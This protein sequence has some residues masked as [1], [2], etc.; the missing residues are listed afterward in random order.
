MRFS[1]YSVRPITVVCA[2]MCLSSLSSFSGL[3]TSAH[4]ENPPTDSDS[5]SRRAQRITPVVRVFQEASPAVVNISTTTV[6]TVQNPAGFGSLFDEI[7]ALPRTRRPRQYRQHSVGSGFLIHSDGYVITNAHV[8]DRVS[9]CKI[10][11]ADGTA[12]LAEEVAID[13]PNDLAVLKVDAAKPLPYL[14]LGQSHDLM[15]GE[16]V[17]AIGNP[18][19]Y[20]H[21]VTTGIISAVNRELR[22]SESLVY[23]GLIQA[24]APINP[25]NSGGPLFNVLG[26]LIGITTAIRG[27]AQNI[28]FAIP[29]N[30]LHKLLPEILD[31]ERLRRVRFGAHF[32]DDLGGGSRGGV[33]VD[34]VDPDSPAA[35]AGLR[36][37]DV[38]TA[39]GA[40]ATPTFME[41]FSVL[42]TT[43]IGQ[44]LAFR[45][46]R[47]G[48]RQSKPV[49]VSLTQI[50]HT[51]AIGLMWNLFGLRVR[52]LTRNDLRRLGL[53][54]PRGLMVVDVRRGSEAD[55]GY[56]L[57]GDIITTFGGWPVTSNDALGHLTKQVNRGDVIPF[58]ILR[59]RQD[60]WFSREFALRAE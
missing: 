49:Y 9:E 21:T 30:K 26:D 10:T 59:I 17:I 44:S 5:E 16:T 41:A 4:A 52:E 57:A 56:M 60:D 53:S 27:D 42:N 3:T 7:F 36:K 18:L 48:K 46:E 51:D 47:D 45:I 32:K 40:R 23:S 28:G 54:R 1:I 38:V 50:P 15:P 20:A 8:V 31:I 25:G 29:V 34:R 22:F 12:L 33:R 14:P 39:I 43:P 35:K 13:R 2:V 37:G 6:V 58:K 11:F 19:G 55:G 24:D